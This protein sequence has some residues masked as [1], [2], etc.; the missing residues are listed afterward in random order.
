MTLK[1]DLA[2]RDL[3]IN[4]MAED[5]HGQLIDP[6][7]GR[8]DLQAGILRHVSLA[9]IE[10]PVRILRVARF[11]AR[12][13]FTVATETMRLMQDMVTQGEVESL[14]PERVW[15]EISRGLMEPTPALMFAVLEEARALPV[16][17][18]ELVGYIT[19]AVA[20]ILEKMAQQQESLLRRFV[21]LTF[22]LEREPL[23]TLGKRLRL[24]QE[25][26]TVALVVNQEKAALAQA[27][28]LSAEALLG[29]LLRCDA[30]RRFTRFQDIVAVMKWCMPHMTARM[31]SFLL[32]A[33]R[34]LKE[35]DGGAI[36]AQC[37]RA[38]EIPAAIRQAQCTCLATVIAA[39]TTPP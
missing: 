10:D 27:L 30:L 22:F 36:A 26:F 34:A 4:A 21:V 29:T 39:Y 14:V 6:F 28:L 37:T 8:R 17:L 35:L 9:F 32:A 3:T 31:T 25:I 5:S 18:P 33:A 16:I 13:Q 12:F 23:Q 2:R 11:A 15:Q 19:P 38:D 1:E 20:Q 24:P 7:Q